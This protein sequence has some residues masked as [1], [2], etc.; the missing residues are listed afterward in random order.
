MRR[1]DADQLGRRAGAAGVERARQRRPAAVDLADH[2]VG[3]ELDIVE[4]QPRRLRAVD[5]RD[6]LD[7]QP[8]APFGDREQGQAVAFAGDPP[9]AR[10]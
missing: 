2:R 4:G 9:C 6:V 1:G 7:L 5:Q 10:R 8:A 3:V